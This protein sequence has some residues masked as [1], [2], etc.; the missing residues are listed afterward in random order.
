MIIT[1]PITNLA[2]SATAC[3][4]FIHASFVPCHK[5]VLTCNVMF[6]I[7]RMNSCCYAKLYVSVTDDHDY[8]E[9]H[10]MIGNGYY[11]DR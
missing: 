10:Q 1:T 7:V 2:Q 4:P 5:L 3:F 6:L 8:T 11:D 9:V